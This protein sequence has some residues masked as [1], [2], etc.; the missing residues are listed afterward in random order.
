MCNILEGVVTNALYTNK[1]RSRRL[2]AHND[3]IFMDLIKIPGEGCHEEDVIRRI[4]H[5]MLQVGFDRV[6]I[7]GLGNVLGFIGSGERIIEKILGVTP[8]NPFL[9]RLTNSLILID[10]TKYVIVNI[11]LLM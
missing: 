5:E 11:A 6:E 3:Q 7:D 8:Y 10:I 9:S 1:S 2:S 4:A